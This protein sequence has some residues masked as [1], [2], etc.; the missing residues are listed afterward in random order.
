MNS[1]S[2][3]D[4]AVILVVMLEALHIAVT[5]Y[6]FAITREPIRRY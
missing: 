2:F 5:A 1:K 4:D 6:R 3:S